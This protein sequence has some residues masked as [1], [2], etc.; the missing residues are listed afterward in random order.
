MV[1]EEYQKFKFR[2]EKVMK[3]FDPIKKVKVKSCISLTQRCQ[4]PPDIK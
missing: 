2:L 3:L 4:K 1:V